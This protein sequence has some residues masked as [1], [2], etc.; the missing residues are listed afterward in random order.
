MDT[1][2][3][4]L[5]EAQQYFLDA[6]LPYRLDAIDMMHLVISMETNQVRPTKIYW[7]NKECNDGFWTGYKNAVIECGIIHARA[8]LDFLGLKIDKNGKL[9]ERKQKHQTDDL[10]IEDFPGHVGSLKPVTIQDI[11][12]RY[13]GPD[14]D[15]L[16][17]IE[18]TILLANKG[19]AHITSADFDN[20]DGWRSLEIVSRGIPSLTVSKFYTPLGL[21]PPE[22]NVYHLSRSIQSYQSSIP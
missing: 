10:V 14:N 11:R 15:A 5:T 8:M 2:S 16:Y 12:S 9:C 17:A 3:V 4:A 20:P 22:S 6:I 18:Y 19:I 21:S 1:K 13:K 7:D